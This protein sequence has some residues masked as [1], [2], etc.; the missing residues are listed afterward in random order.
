MPTATAKGSATPAGELPL[1]TLRPLPA[2]ETQGTG[3]C[4]TRLADAGPAAAQAVSK[5]T[6]PRPVLAGHQILPYAL[7]TD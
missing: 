1:A 5:V 7:F 3:T 6:V 2:R 4:C